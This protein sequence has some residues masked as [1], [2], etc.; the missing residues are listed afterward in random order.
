MYS[1]GPN[2]HPVD[3]ILALRSFMHSQLQERLGVQALSGGAQNSVPA[4][5]RELTLEMMP[6]LSLV[7]PSILSHLSSHMED[8]LPYFP[9]ETNRSP[10]NYCTQLR[11]QALWN[12]VSFPLSSSVALMTSVH[13]GGSS[14]S[15]PSVGKQGGVVREL[16]APS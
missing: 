3:Q 11:V 6:G 15:K 8:M 16:E 13:R 9:K 12:G 1:T 14:A 5:P 2:S 4:A 10:L 7:A